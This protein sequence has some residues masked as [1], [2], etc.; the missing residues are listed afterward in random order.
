MVNSDGQRG[1]ESKRV[2][3][4]QSLFVMNDNDDGKEETERGQ[5]EIGLRI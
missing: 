1:K 3:K 5:V 4:R 2:R